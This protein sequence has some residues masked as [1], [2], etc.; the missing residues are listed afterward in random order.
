MNSVYHNALQGCKEELFFMLYYTVQRL[1]LMS[2]ECFALKMFLLCIPVKFFIM[3][4]HYK[5]LTC[6]EKY[7]RH[8]IV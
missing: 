7:N 6:S 1:H 8:L 3:D 5:K 2:C 4:Q